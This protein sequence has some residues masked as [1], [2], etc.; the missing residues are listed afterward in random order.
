MKMLAKQEALGAAEP[1]RWEPWLLLRAWGHT[2]TRGGLPA[3]GRARPECA[4][5]L[6]VGLGSA[7]GQGS[8][9]VGLCKSALREVTRVPLLQGHPLCKLRGP[10]HPHAYFAGSWCPMAPH[11]TSPPALRVWL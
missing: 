8:L 11:P 3:P 10:R 1:R 5:S 9:S 7:R 2:G 4:R 6:W